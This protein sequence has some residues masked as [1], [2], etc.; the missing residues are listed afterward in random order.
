[1]VIFIASYAIFMNYQE[2]FIQVS[3]DDQINDVGAFIT[4]NILKIAGKEDPTE[5]KI[6]IEIPPRIGNEPYS[7]MLSQA[8]LNITTTQT[9]KTRMFNIYGLSK[10]YELGG[11]RVLST[12]A[13]EILIYKKGNRIILL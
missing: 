6:F 12:E 4:T 5:A 1:V 10:Y 9:G 11:E 13:S 7:V 3:L 8:G 2:H